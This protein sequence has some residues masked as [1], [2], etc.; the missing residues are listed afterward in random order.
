MPPVGIK[1]L[2]IVPTMR[3]NIN[4]AERKSI[5]SLAARFLSE[6]PALCS[7]GGVGPRVTS[8]L[9]PWPCFVI[10]DHSA[11][12]L[13][14]RGGDLRYSYRAMLLAGDSDMVAV[15]VSPCPAFEVYCRETL[16]LGNVEVLRPQ[17]TSLPAPLAYRCANDEALLEHVAQKARQRN[18]LNVIPYM[19]TGHVW[20]LAQRIAELAGVDIRVAAPPPRLTRRVN[21]KL[22]FSDKAMELLGSQSV[23]SSHPVYGMAAL[24]GRVA[25]Y[26]KSHAAIAV[27][28]PSS[29]S[30]AGNIVL[31]SQDLS[32]HTL[33]DLHNLL[34]SRLQ[35]IGWSGHFP[36]MVTAWE[37]PILASPSVQL[38][39]PSKG[40]EGIV[41]EGIFD[42]VVI[43]K[44]R[45]FGGAEPTSLGPPWQEHLTVGATKL[46]LLFQ[47]L[48][49]FG[50]CSFDAI[51]V[52]SGEAEAQ[53]HWIECNGRWGGTSI[54][55]TLANRLVGNWRHHPFIVIERDDLYGPRRN[56][57][58]FLQE[59]RDRLYIPEKRQDGAVLLS[60]GQ[61]ELG[62]GFEM[63]VIG[64]N[65]ESARNQALDLCEFFL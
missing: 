47:D 55:M 31:E 34:A 8:G 52:G 62:T 13:F 22:W 3:A 41:V 37:S 1:S 9:G 38:W 20:V 33:K 26:A 46:G 32:G 60:P 29:A 63:M 14:E 35:M 7:M 16:G 23:P 43:G 15:G 2:P 19:G 30:S 12:S 59:I 17:S 50:R 21:D 48:G 65:L 57:D 27:K 54:P 56:V 58:S 18:G 24:A 40:K 45:A 61:I 36:I 5:A 44:T 28:L 42:Q 51:L 6:E 49:Y 4:E 10:E 39:I 53:L 64:E 25:K 11:I